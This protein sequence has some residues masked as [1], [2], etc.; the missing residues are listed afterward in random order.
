MS[1]GRPRTRIKVVDRHQLAATITSFIDSEFGGVITAASNALG[2]ERSLLSRMRAGVAQSLR[3]S[4]LRALRK[5]LTPKQFAE[6]ERCIVD[7][8][9]AEHLSAF[10][11]WLKAEHTR[12]LYRE[13][14]PHTVVGR[15]IASVAQWSTQRLLEYDHLLGVVQQ[16]FPDLVRNFDRFLKGRRHF[17]ARGDLA[18]VRILAPLLDGADSG[19]IERRWQELSSGE[20]RRFIKCGMKRE[21]ILLDRPPDM[22]RAEEM[23][24][25]DPIE[26]VAL[27][28]QLWDDR[29]FTGRRINPLIARWIA[30]RR[31]G[32]KIALPLAPRAASR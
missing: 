29:A 31:R 32:L 16:S 21:M 30:Q 13:A 15:A 28:G 6:I 7:P 23:L 17:K 5:R 27:Y 1:R 25:R 4:D 18:Y 10:D 12:L 20:L 3:E 24:T 8:P 9:L 11:A 2:I 26:F 14:A 22:Q 19:L